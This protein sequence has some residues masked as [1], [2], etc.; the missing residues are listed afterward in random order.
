MM[1]T[2]GDPRTE[3]AKVADAQ[4]APYLAKPYT[5]MIIPNNE[6]GGFIAEVL[7][8]PGCMTEGDSAEEAYINLED[9]MTGYIGV[10][11]DEGKEV[12]APMGLNEYSGRFLLRFSGELHRSATMRAERENVSLNQWIGQAVAERL[13]GKTLA[14]EIVERLGGTAF[15][16]RTFTEVEFHGA[17][18]PGRG[19]SFATPLFDPGL[20]A[21][22]EP[23][24]GR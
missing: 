15:R 11:L 10:L 5:R 2:K 1:N 24:E 22:P 16:V 8:L 21:T 9:A 7:E 4:I 6:D 13:M 17:N 20:L 12:P 19:T 18:P 14:D 23:S 3:V